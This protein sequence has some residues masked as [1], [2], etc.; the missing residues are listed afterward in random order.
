MK[1]PHV[2]VVE[3]DVSML[4]LFDS[5]LAANGYRV[6]TAVGVSAARQALEEADEPFQLALI[7]FS[8]G[9]EASRVAE[10]LR[11]HSRFRRTPI[12]ALTSSTRAEDVEVVLDSGCDAYLRKPFHL[13]EFQ[14]M[15]VSLVH[16]G[17]RSATNHA[18]S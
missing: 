7:D 15:L 3:N 9:T 11:A 10:M 16:N 1:R 17:S 12:L 6:T 8:P 2:L 13:D 18:A 4:R 14:D 5:L